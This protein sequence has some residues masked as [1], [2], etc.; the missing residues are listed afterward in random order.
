MILDE[1]PLMTAMRYLTYGI[2]YLFYIVMTLIERTFTSLNI[3][4]ALISAVE[5]LLIV[6]IL[7]EKKLKSDYTQNLDIK[8]LLD[9]WKTILT[10][11]SLYALKEGYNVLEAAGILRILYGYELLDLLFLVVLIIGLYNFYRLLAEP[12]QNKEVKE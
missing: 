6:G 12:A 9:V 7:A 5:C 8:K 4:L 10:A 3:I 1:D 11:I 2:A